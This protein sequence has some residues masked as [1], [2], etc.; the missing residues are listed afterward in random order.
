[1]V[2]RLAHLGI[3][4]EKLFDELRD[5]TE[6]MWQTVRLRCKDHCYKVPVNG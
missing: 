5:K 2:A 1:M 6:D 4:E 3:G